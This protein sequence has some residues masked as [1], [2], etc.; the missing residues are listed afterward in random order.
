MASRDE[1]R[2]RYGRSYIPPFTKG[3]GCV[4]SCGDSYTWAPAAALQIV[5]INHTPILLILI[6]AKVPQRI[7]RIGEHET[8]GAA[9][10]P[11]RAA[12]FLAGRIPIRDTDTRTSSAA[13]LPHTPSANRCSTRQSALHLLSE[14]EEEDWR[15]RER[16]LSRS[17][18]QQRGR[19]ETTREAAPC[20]LGVVRR[21]SEPTAR[22]L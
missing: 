1:G 15:G 4:V 9:R 21:R 7:L 13:S 20:P 22:M 12:R 19:P 18:P 14:K 16:M 8:F 6:L 11:G 3:G 17:S 5:I 10:A 2:N